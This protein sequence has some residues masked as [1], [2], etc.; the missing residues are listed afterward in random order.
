VQ[1]HHH[2][3][4]DPEEDDVEAGDQGVGRV[5]ARQV[6]RLLGQP[7]VENGQSAEENQVSSTSSSWRSGSSRP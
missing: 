3:P 4:G 6:G 2:H 7:R 5:E 1:A